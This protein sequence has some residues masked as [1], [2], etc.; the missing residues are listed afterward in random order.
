MKLVDKY[1]REHNYLRVSV[2]D[3]CN[4]NCSYC[5]PKKDFVKYNSRNNILSFEEICRIVKIFAE[6]FEFRKIRLTGGEPFARKN[7]LNLVGML[8]EIKSQSSFE[9]SATSNA[10]LLNGKVY[11]YRNAGIDRFNFSLDSLNKTGFNSIS[12]SADYEAAVDTILESVNLMPGK[13]KINVVVMKGINDQELLDFTEF[14]I[15]HDVPVR[16]IE[17]MPFS[18]NEYNKGMFISCD[19]MIGTI[20]EKYK[21]MP[22]ARNNE[23]VSKDYRIEGERGQISFITSISEHFCADCNRLRL[24]SDGMLKLCLFSTVD[25]D[26]D[27]R[28]MI[29]SGSDDSEI[30]NAIINF[31]ERKNEM[32]EPVENLIKLK[33][34]RMISIGG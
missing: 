22:L 32:H 9:L 34:N 19:E 27:L 11:E 12:G 14:S 2:T 29:L 3:R 16:F 23:S 20:S 8:T 17:Y 1:N 33:N 31:I 15:K 10:V 7:I 30:E 5:N 21:L 26:L 13:I 6:R 25:S 18:D 4:L 28:N 24:T